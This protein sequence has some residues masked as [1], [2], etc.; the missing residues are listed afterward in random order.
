MVKPLKD[1]LLIT[2]VDQLQVQSAE[3]TILVVIEPPTE[4]PLILSNVVSLINP[5]E[6][7][8]RMNSI[9]SLDYRSW[10]ARLRFLKSYLRTHKYVSSAPMRPRHTRRGLMNIF[11]EI[12]HTLF[13]LATDSSVEECRQAVNDVRSMQKAVVHQVNRLT[14][15]L[16]QTQ[17][18]VALNRY[19]VN[20]LANFISTSLVPKLHLAL[21]VLN[22]TNIRLSLL[23]RTFYF[24][25]TISLLEQVTTSYI[26]SVRRY[27]RQKASL[28]VGRLTE[29]ILPIPQLREVLSKAD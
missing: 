12:G 15:V 10:L 25:R 19:N 8:F 23:E 22:N 14:T 21:M 17:Q 7:A 6:R 29:D 11:G 27:S 18:T 1:G 16:N 5:L 26:G 4:A 24:E 20:K 13:G 2:K 3:W 9:T 28:E